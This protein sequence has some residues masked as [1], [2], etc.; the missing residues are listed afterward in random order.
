MSLIKKKNKML[1]SEIFLFR[2]FSWF[3][4]GSVLW[5]NDKIFCQIKVEPQAHSAIIIFDNFF[6]RFSVEIQK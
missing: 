1:E 5:P 3:S 2:P 4:K 6:E